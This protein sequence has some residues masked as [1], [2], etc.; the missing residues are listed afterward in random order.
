VSTFD[1]ERAGAA[2]TLA[3]TP[4]ATIAAAVAVCTGFTLTATLQTADS[5]ELVPFLRLDAVLLAAAATVAVDDVAAALTVSAPVGRSTQRRW[6]LALVGLATAVSYVA[7]LLV[8]GSARSLDGIPVVALATELVGLVS[9]GWALAALITALTGSTT[10]SRRAAPLLIVS[11]LLSVTIPSISRLLWSRPA[12]GWS[13]VQTR[14][15]AIA[16]AALACVGWA[17]RDRRR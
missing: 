2:H 7:I 11:A 3:R 14:W 6:S 4:R 12:P 1:L 13:V 10:P 5:S 9:F 8:V 16:T 15:V 17:T